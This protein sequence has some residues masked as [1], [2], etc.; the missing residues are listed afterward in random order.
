MYR[1]SQ[2][3]Q[4]G[5]EG[6]PMDMERAIQWMEG[7]ANIGNRDAM[8]AIRRLYEADGPYKD[9]KRA[10]YWAEQSSRASAAEAARKSA[11]LNA[12]LAESAR[13][14]HEY[15]METDAV[16]RSQVEYQQRAAQSVSSGRIPG[17]FEDSMWRQNS[18]NNGGRDLGGGMY[19][20]QR[21]SSTGERIIEIKFR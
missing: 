15:R 4:N 8:Y 3:Y 9:T 19:S 17:A 14:N 1:L 21:T 18:W 16:Y 11:E 20:S 10:R 6:A 5:Q 13:K 2:Y 7:A 12:Y